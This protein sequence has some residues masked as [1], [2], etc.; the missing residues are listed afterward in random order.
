MRHI[1]KFLL[2]LTS[3]NVSAQNEFP[4]IQTIEVDDKVFH[5]QIDK[6]AIT[7]YLKFHQYSNYH[8]GA[9]AVNGWYHYH[10]TMKQIPLTGL[11]DRGELVLYNFTDSSRSKD[12]LNF[13]DRK[14]NHLEDMN[15]YKNFTGFNEKFV[16]S[17][18]ACSWQNNTD[19]LNVKL[20]DKDLKIKQTYEF[21]MLDE[22][23]AFDLHN[24][25]WW[26]WNFKIVANN[27][28][29]MILE[30]DH[31]SKLYN[32][33]RCAAG[34]EKGFVALEFDDNNGFVGSEKF[35]LESCLFSIEAQ[36]HNQLANEV[37]EYSCENF[38]NSEA[39]VLIVDYNKVEITQKEKK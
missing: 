39:Y 14:S 2:I 19:F 8:R 29:K 26:N 17:D 3:Y 21:L 18:S 31:A 4:R 34:S 22:T 30:Y 27:Q 33:G 12:M 20:Q 10:E 36:T 6:N 28:R 7:I 24:L 9:Y 37:L 1:L 38:L 35:I 5:G 16:F 23:K 11:Y 25:G 32:T 13:V 15:Y